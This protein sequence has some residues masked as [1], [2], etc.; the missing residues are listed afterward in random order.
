MHKSVI[1]IPCY[2]EA[3]RLDASA[4]HHLVR[5]PGIDLLFVNDGSTDRT[6]IVLNELCATMENR[7]TLFTLAHNSGKAEAVRQGMLRAL[8]SGAD[9]VGY[10]DADLATPPREM[11]RLIA[12]LDESG[13]LV[14]LAS[15]VRL[16]GTKIERRAMRH[17]LGRIFATVASLC[18][19]IPVYDTQCGAKVFR[20]SE[21]LR[22]ALADPFTSRWGFDVELIGRLLIGNQGIPGFSPDCFLE[23][24]L[25]SWRD[26]PGSKLRAS[27]FPKTMFELV[28]ITIS[29]RRRAKRTAAAIPT[30]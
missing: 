28:R 26:V 12:A 9:V 22:E 17:Y 24:P 25:K 30:A 16:L 19:G 3:N 5:I 13:A 8:D 15:R 7:A 11:L 27:D 18:V 14:V 20:A 1:V 10:Y 29:L 21:S 4:F 23:M 2:N 6:S